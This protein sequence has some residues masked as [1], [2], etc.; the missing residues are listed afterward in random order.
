MISEVYTCT[1]WNL[2]EDIILHYTRTTWFLLH[3]YNLISG[4]YNLIS[5][6][7]TCTTWNLYLYGKITYFTLDS[8]TLIFITFAKTWFP[9]LFHSCCVCIFCYIH[10]YFV[11]IFMS[12]PSHCLLTC[13][14]YSFVIDLK[15]VKKCFQN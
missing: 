3:S 14:S 15:W 2:S 4:L 8:H 13:E 7:Y 1:T 9:W 6:F 5:G 11:L 10:T 12:T